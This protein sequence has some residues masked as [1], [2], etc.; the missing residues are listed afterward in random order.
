MKIKVFRP[1]AL[2]LSLLGIAIASP[3]VLPLQRAIAAQAPATPSTNLNDYVANHLDDFTT[4]MKVLAHDDNAGRKINKDFGM[5]YQLKGDVTLNYKEE[6]KLRLDGHIGASKGTFIVNNTTQYVRLSVGINDKRDLGKSPGKRKTLLDVGLIST[7]Y[8]AYAEGQ[9]LGP[10]PV[11]GVICQVFRIS[12]KDKSLDTS[13]RIVWIDPKTKV[14]LKREEYSQKGKLNATFYYKEPK[15]VA[16]GVWFPSRIEVYNNEGQKAGE[17]S[18]S[19]TK[20]NQGLSDS[21]FHL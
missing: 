8:L 10:R 20:V 12:Y 6:N 1:A 18:Y 21:L 16:P 5:I 15:E 13:H 14:T 9:A 11:D 7:G 4:M 3:L 17:T 19:S 2:T